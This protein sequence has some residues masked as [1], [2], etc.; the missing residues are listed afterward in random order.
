[1][2]AINKVLLAIVVYEE[3]FY[4]TVVYSSLI[5]SLREIRMDDF[6]IA[7]YDNT[8]TPD[9]KINCDVVPEQHNIIYH[10]DPENPGIS[11]A[12]NYM[13][14]LAASEGKEWIIFFDQD[15]EVP[16]NAIE[17]Y[18]RAIEE[19]PDVALKAAILHVGAKIFSPSK[20]LFKKSIALLDISPGLYSLNKIVVVNSGL[21]VDLDLFFKA[22]GYNE[23]V[24]LDFAD[25]QFIERVRTVTDTVEIL[26]VTCK[27]G[28]SDNESN[29]LKALKRYSF[30]VEDM[31]NCQRRNLADHFGF[32]I[33]DL[34][35]LVKLSMKFRSLRFL[36]LRLKKIG[37]RNG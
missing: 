29:V 37:T 32:L 19:K 3:K 18:L 14:K 6:E 8:D 9:W 27:H 33:V 5:R 28:F 30:F 31:L 10:H 16:A 35:R 11:K 7:I 22:G 15:T 26:P 12:Y 34:S 1:M 20:Y 2:F 21:A 17:Q 25:F 13:A 36:T 24:R 23:K 4:E